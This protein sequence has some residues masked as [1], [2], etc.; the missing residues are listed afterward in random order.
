MNN[1][2]TARD[3]LENGQC[4]G[5]DAV[6]GNMRPNPVGSTSNFSS[7][8]TIK[9]YLAQNYPKSVQKHSSVTDCGGLFV[10]G[11]D[12]FAYAIKTAQFNDTVRVSLKHPSQRTP[13]LT[14][15]NGGQNRRPPLGIADHS[16]FDPKKTGITGDCSCAVIAHE[17]E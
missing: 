1:E 4:D 8:F 17:K 16:S 6:G 7:E 9:V 10:P 13:V 15:K 3:A 11:F 14:P 5:I 12:G 2:R